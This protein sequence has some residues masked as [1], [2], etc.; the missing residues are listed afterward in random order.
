MAEKSPT[1][2]GGSGFYRRQKMRCADVCDGTFDVDEDGVHGR[3]V[4]LSLCSPNDVQGISQRSIPPVAANVDI[5]G[6]DWATAMYINTSRPPP[7]SP[8]SSLLPPAHGVQP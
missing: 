5:V 4:H 1:V 6:V 8:T 2:T 3:L 7:S